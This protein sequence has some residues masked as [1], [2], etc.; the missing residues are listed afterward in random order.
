M[1]GDVWMAYVSQM[2]T[3]AI[4]EASA[5]IAKFATMM[6]IAFLPAMVAK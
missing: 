6:A 5:V 4:W 3:S 1:P 2:R